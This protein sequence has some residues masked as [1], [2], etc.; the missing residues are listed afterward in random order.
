M[1]DATEAGDDEWRYEMSEVLERAWGFR[2]RPGERVKQPGIFYCLACGVSQPLSA[3]ETARDCVRHA[4]PIR[5]GVACRR[6]EMK[7]ASRGKW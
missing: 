4:T 1:T 3:G 7:S 6:R 5:M 2:V